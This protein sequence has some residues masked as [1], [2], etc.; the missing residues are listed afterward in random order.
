MDKKE[1]REL[2]LAE[3]KILKEVDRICKK[4]NLTYYL[5][6]GTA[7]G[8]VRHNGFIPWDDDI[9]IMMPWRDY[10][11]F[12]RIV[13]KE[14]SAEFHCQDFIREPDVYVYWMKMR[15]NNTTCMDPK[16]KELDIHWG[17]G[18]DIFPLFPIE[19]RE[20][21]FAKKVEYKALRFLCNESF[22]CCKGYPLTIKKRV[23]CCMYA[24][25]P[26]KVSQKIKI[27]LL[28]R[29]GKAK[30]DV[31]YYMEISEGI[32]HNI[33]LSDIEGKRLQL[34]EGEEYPVPKE[35]EKYLNDCYGDD[36]MIVPDVKEQY[37]HGNLILDFEH[38]CSKYK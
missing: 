20:L 38:D 10:Q 5:A 13:D 37:N 31:K 21:S 30:S 14:T 16:E 17:I 7:L 19:E 29:L 15:L 34:F 35:L 24:I 6:W 33:V 28:N 9:D 2:Q 22:V 4:H 23:L 27:S 18:I 12:N 1:L 26:K 11:V 32:G 36:Y 8:A 3:L 25:I